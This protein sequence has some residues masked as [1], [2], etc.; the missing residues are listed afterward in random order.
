M[1]MTQIEELRHISSKDFASLGMQDLAF[2][3]P[4]VV[5]DEVGYAIHAADGTQMAVIAN[6]DVAFAAVRQHDLQ[7][8]SVH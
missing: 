5:N 4:V 7:P 3:K 2:I 8:V 6:R 1:V